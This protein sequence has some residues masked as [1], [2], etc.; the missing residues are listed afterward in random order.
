M[1]ESKCED[2]HTKMSSLGGIDCSE[3]LTV[4]QNMDNARDEVYGTALQR[5]IDQLYQEN[6]EKEIS[7]GEKN[8]CDLLDERRIHKEK[9][10][11]SQLEDI[12]QVL[13]SQL[14]ELNMRRLEEKLA[15][16]T[17]Q[18]SFFVHEALHDKQRMIINRNSR[19][20]MQ[21][22]IES[23]ILEKN[24]KLKEDKLKRLSDEQ[25]LTKLDMEA[26]TN[27]MEQKRLIKLRNMKVALDRK[28]HED[29]LC[30]IKSK[31]QTSDASSIAE[32]ML[33]Q[34]PELRSPL[35]SQGGYR[36]MDIGFDSRR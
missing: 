24:L 32:F 5:W 21:K 25:T 3:G 31:A 29:K 18:S 30:L 8:L 20:N 23:D 4:K 27:D 19:G 7:Q 34:F 1:Q 28:A 2:I 9:V 16:R 36:G 10:A 26:F 22:K 33:T 6:R 11:R 13:N 15:K 35:K 12:K 14:D 17:F